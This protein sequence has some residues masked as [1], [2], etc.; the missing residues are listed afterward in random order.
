MIYNFNNQKF[1]L[2]LKFEKN[3]PKNKTVHK[4]SFCNLKNG[5]GGDSEDLEDFKDFEEE[6]SDWAAENYR[7]A[8][9][10]IHEGG[11]RTG[12]EVFRCF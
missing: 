5:K 11:V 1:S 9:G 8:I 3:E 12:F 6:N 10:K 7:K 2:N 4:D